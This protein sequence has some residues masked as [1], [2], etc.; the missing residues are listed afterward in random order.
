MD[1]EDDAHPRPPVQLEDVTDMEEPLV[2]LHHEP[3]PGPL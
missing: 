3:R 2:V 1:V